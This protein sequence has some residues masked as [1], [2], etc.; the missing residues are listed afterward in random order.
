MRD[1]GLDVALAADG[2]DVRP[3]KLAMDVEPVVLEL[4]V[5]HAFAPPD[6]CEQ[7]HVEDEPFSDR[8]GA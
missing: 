1:V 6:E 8:S 2:V 4:L 3:H 7:L 5:R